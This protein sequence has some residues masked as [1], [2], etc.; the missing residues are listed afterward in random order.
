MSKHQ[1]SGGSKKTGHSKSTKSKKVA[2]VADMDIITNE[3]RPVVKSKDYSILTPKQLAAEQDK[4]V[5]ATCELLCIPPQ[6]CYQLLAYFKWNKDI[7]EEKY[8]E[9]SESLMKKAGIINP[10]EQELEPLKGEHECTICLCDYSAKEM[11]QLPCAHVFCETCMTEYIVANI[12]DVSGT[13]LRCPHRKC[14]IQLD[15]T[16]IEKALERGKDKSFIQKYQKF[17]TQSYVQDNDHMKWCPG[18]NCDNAIRVTLLKE[19]LVIC[20]CSCQFC[21]AC[22]NLPHPPAS[23]QMMKNW[24]KQLEEAMKDPSFNRAQVRANKAQQGQLTSK[25][26]LDDE[27]AKFFA[28]NTK[29]CPQCDASIIKD[30]GCQY[31]RCGTCKHGFCWICLGPFDHV[32]H[33]CNAYVPKEGTDQNVLAKF[34]FFYTRYATHNQA[35][36]LEQKLQGLA[37]QMR[38][39]LLNQGLTHI[40]ANFVLDATTILSDS[41]AILKRS[42]VFGYFL[43]TGIPRTIFESLQEE[44]EQRIESLSGYLEAKD[45]KPERTKIVNLMENIKL[46]QKTFLDTLDDPTWR[47]GKKE[48][49][50][51][52]SKYGAKAFADK[53]VEY[54]GWIYEQ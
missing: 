7:L 28:S 43:P 14:N 35:A 46:R 18:K 11:Q 34:A 23:C 21:F 2:V 54:S 31:I 36:E 17:R 52:F 48:D 45:Q 41:R 51:D 15:S 38:N 42:Y 29:E 26:K 12:I 27:T 33:G 8:F 3:D 50:E 53:K 4:I 49:T 5:E 9:D 40:E 13:G 6:T 39:E 44:F 1:H 16:I 10:D 47:T 19:P 24:D 25:G 30:G 32:K 22:G 37:I 20:E